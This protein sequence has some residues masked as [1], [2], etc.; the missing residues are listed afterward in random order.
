V[1]LQMNKARYL[2]NLPDNKDAPFGGAFSVYNDE[3]VFIRNEAINEFSRQPNFFNQ[4][5]IRKDFLNTYKE[6]AFSTH[7]Q[8]SGIG[9]YDKLCFTNG[10]T[11]SFSHFYLRYR[12]KKRLRL[13]KGEYFY[14]Q[15][16][17]A[18]WYTDRFAWLDEDHIKENDFVLLSVPFSDNGDVPD[19]LEKM[20]I[21]CDEKNV[22]VMLDFAY[23]NLAVNFKV[24]VNHP[25]IEYIVT[26]LSKVFPVENY[27]IGMRM[28]RKMFTDQL[29]VINE[30]GYNYINLLS[31]SVGTK[32]MKNFEADFIFTKYRS[33]QI[34]MCKKYNLKISP[35]VYFGI[36][37]LD[38]YPLYNR[39]TKTNRLCFSKIWDGRMK[40]PDVTL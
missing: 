32:L 21:D 7:T 14:S 38:Q 22:P 25:C 37:H 13:A 5:K 27:R 33:K 6:W 36:D 29:Y 8:I 16:M 9:A 19:Y 24:D 35:C 11:E 20:L 23:L 26:S 18:L 39:G 2:T 12:E 31:A 28:Q 34:D 40:E 1:A 30:D 4:D 17:K 15:M 3:T 10:T